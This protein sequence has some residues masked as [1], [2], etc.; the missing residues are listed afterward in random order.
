MTVYY[1][2]D[3]EGNWCQYDEMSNARIAEA[4][5][6][7]APSVRLNILT[8][9]GKHEMFE[10]RFGEN[11]FSEQIR[12]P[13]STQIIQVNLETGNTRVVKKKSTAFTSPSEQNRVVARTLSSHNHFGDFSKHTEPLY[14]WLLKKM[15]KGWRKGAWNR[16]FFVLSPKFKSLLYY[17]KG[18]HSRHVSAAREGDSAAPPAKS[19]IPLQGAVIIPTTVEDDK[20]FSFTIRIPGGEYNL[21]AR[22]ADLKEKWL[23]QITCVAHGKEVGTP[24]YNIQSRPPA[25]PNPQTLLPSSQTSQ[26]TSMQNIQEGERV[27]IP[28]RANSTMPSWKPSNSDCV[29]PSSPTYAPPPTI[30]EN[31]ASAPPMPPLRPAPP[32]PPL[33]PEEQSGLSSPARRLSCIVGGEVAEEHSECAV[34]FDELHARQIGVLVD[35]NNARICRHLFHLDCLEDLVKPG[36]N[37]LCPMCRKVSGGIVALPSVVSDPHRWFQ[38]LDVDHTGRIESEDVLITLKAQLKC[39]EEEL[40]AQWDKLW[41]SFDLDHSGS[42]TYD[43]LVHPDRGLV[44]ALTRVLGLSPD[45]VHALQNPMSCTS[46]HNQNTPTPS[47]LHNAPDLTKDKH[48]WFE[49]WDEDN[50]GTLDEGELLRALVHSFNKRGQRNEVREMKDIVHSLLAACDVS[51]DGLI[52]RDEFLASSVGLADV[53]I[54]NFG[55]FKQ[56]ASQENQTSSSQQSTPPTSSAIDELMQLEIRTNG[57]HHYSTSDPSLAGK[58]TINTTVRQ[59][60][61]LAAQLHNNI[62]PNRV[63][64][65]CRG[66]RLDNDDLKLPD[67]GIR[68]G[69]SLMLVISS[70]S[71]VRLGSAGAAVMAANSFQNNIPQQNPAPSRPIVP[72]SYTSAPHLP[73]LPPPA[74]PKNQCRVTVPPNAGPGSLLT[75]R[76][77]NTNNNLQVRVPSGY[78]PGTTFTISYD[79]NHLSPQQQAPPPQQQQRPFSAPRPSTNGPGGR[80]MRVKVPAGVQP[81]QELMVNVPGTG[82][83]RVTV[84]QG[85][86]PGMEFDFRLP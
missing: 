52:S 65:V 82:R 36:E 60:R 15:T 38:L 54:A 31:H 49:F 17:T 7:G 81:G 21:S 26:N 39:R 72:P 44:S 18:L 62:N 34:C 80:V 57:G 77:P 61:T 1:H 4:E 20:P 51:G 67:A 83:C 48:A 46:E 33:S 6:L 11:A 50:S 2:R 58:I 32:P 42:L 9:L 63:I 71:S 14:G 74:T 79:P 41:D 47:Y 66:Q 35:N 43:E 5:E 75:I 45:D 29:S 56:A 13:P 23:A 12:Q 53:I 22:S 85:V 59:L 27:Q 64:L 10:I 25:Y 28:Q 76:V 84:P 30:T 40:D 69:D 37:I 70:S 24:T 16:R 86:C 19:Q 55:F 73:Q 68:S 3:K 8:R 78:F